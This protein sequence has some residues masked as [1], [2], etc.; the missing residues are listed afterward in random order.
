MVH[1]HRAHNAEVL[2]LAE[3]ALGLA[4]SLLQDAW[5]GSIVPAIQACGTAVAQL[6]GH[7]LYFSGMVG[8]VRRWELLS[9]AAVG[10]TEGREEVLKSSCAPGR[11]GSAQVPQEI[12]P[13]SSSR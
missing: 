11:G 7:A 3:G 5:I 9:A 8:A 4:L 1:L 10:V 13:S 2:C 6:H 12:Y